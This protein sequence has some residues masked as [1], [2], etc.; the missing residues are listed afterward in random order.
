MRTRWERRMRRQERFW[1]FA[2]VLFIALCCL[3]TW[4]VA[5]LCMG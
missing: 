2:V 5:A 1:A 3:L 4:E